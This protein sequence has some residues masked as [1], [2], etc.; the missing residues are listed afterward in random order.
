[1]SWKWGALLLLCLASP[2]WATSGA[3]YLGTWKQ[4]STVPV[5]FVVSSAPTTAE[6][7]LRAVDGTALDTGSMT[8]IGTTSAYTYE[9]LADDTLGVVLVEMADAGS[10]TSI[11]TY[12]KVVRPGEVNARRA[13]VDY[14]TDRLLR[15]QPQGGNRK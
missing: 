6:I 12:F 15:L 1:M 5:V 11:F 13:D 4:G 7:T 14:A 3:E 8:R 2:S 10:G 9:Y